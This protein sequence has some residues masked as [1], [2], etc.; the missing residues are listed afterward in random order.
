MQ[1]FEFLRVVRHDDPRDDRRPREHEARQSACI[2]GRKRKQQKL[3]VLVAAAG[4]LRDE[5]H[6][7]PKV[8]HGLGLVL[9][10]GI[11]DV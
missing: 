4:A 7:P 6:H 2:G 11:A 10:I 1:L 9:V 5:L 8:A 3:L